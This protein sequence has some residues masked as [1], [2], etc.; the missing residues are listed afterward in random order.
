MIPYPQ[1]DPVIISIGPLSVRWYGLMY[2]ISFVVAYFLVRRQ[3]LSD[4]EDDPGK[5]LQFLENLIFWLILGLIIGARL[6][7]CLFYGSENY[8]KN[9]L[10]L[11]AVWH[12]GMS[13]HGGAIGAFLAGLLYCRREGEDFWLWAD[14]FGVVIPVGLFLG[15]IGNFINGELY[16]RVTDVP[17]AM[18]FPGGGPLL[19]HPSQLYEAFLEG[20]VLFM[21]LWSI[22]QKSWPSGRKLALFFILY[23]LFRIFVEFFREPDVQLGFVF[24]GWLTMGQVLSFF[25]LLAGII[26][27]FLRKA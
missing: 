2:L 4:Y 11:L 10:E 13:F 9:P 20:I 21:V 7:Y 12:G 25:L 19:R 14:R 18:V 1:I 16:G 27:W 26:L 5:K 15:R 23:S 22:R 24:L 6:G 8:L 17:W 3:V